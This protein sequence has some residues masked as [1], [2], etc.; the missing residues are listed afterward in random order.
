MIHRISGFS[1][2]VPAFSNWAEEETT[3]KRLKAEG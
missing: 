2:Q 3:E 1:I